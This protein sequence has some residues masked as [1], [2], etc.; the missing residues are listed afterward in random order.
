M[1][2]RN[3]SGAAVVLVSLAVALTAF[4][5]DAPAGEGLR[6][7]A[8]Q[9][10]GYENDIYC[11]GYLGGLGESFP[12]RI[13]GG[14]KADEQSG[15]SISDIVYADGTGLNAG[16]EYWLVSEGESVLDPD[17]GRDLGVFYQYNG[18]ARA[19]C[20]RGDTAVLQIT[21]MCTDIAPGVFLKPFEPVP[22]PLARRTL[23]LTACDESTGKA[24]GRIIYV[25]DDKPGLAAGEDV[26]IDL[27]SD[28]NLSPGDFLTIFREST[29]R[30]F[31]VT[32]SG[33]LSTFA[34]TN[35]HR[36]QL[37]EIALLTVSDRYSVARVT[38]SN[39]EI[40][41]GDRVEIK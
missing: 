29:P 16:D 34:S 11:F 17:D 2:T 27:G 23:P 22:V 21:F 14:E 10:V 7:E 32:Y 15:F 25:R 39:F 4:G 41:L 19:L 20:V 8:P 30:E 24:V 13:V 12:A 28:A 3:L 18:R 36:T 6:V 35:T 1:K 26:I 37:G 31:N 38:A 9:P 40:R 33:H 5:Q